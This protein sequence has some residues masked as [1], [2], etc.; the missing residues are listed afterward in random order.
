MTTD[1][2]PADFGWTPNWDDASG[3]FDWWFH[4]MDSVMNAGVA[5]AT[6]QLD[7][8]DEVGF[9]AVRKL[10]ELARSADVR[11]W[12]L[13]VSFTHPHDPHVMRRRYWDRYDLNAIDLPRVGPLS[14]DQLDAHSRRLRHVSAMDEVEITEEHVRRARRAYYAAISY[15]DDWVATL[16]DKLEAC[17]M[18]DD[19]VVIFTADHGD[20]L[21][22]RGLWY[23][24]CF[25][26]GACRI[27]LVVAG[28]DIAARLVPE[29]VSL[30]DVLPTLLDLAGV[31]R[32]ATVDGRSLVP[33]LSGDRDPD[34]TVIGEYLA[35]GAIAPILMIR[36]RELKFVWCDADPPQLYDLGN[37]PD[38]LVNLAA[39]DDHRAVVAELEKE[40]LARWAPVTLRDEVIANQRARRT[41][42]A[43][44]RSGRYSLWEYQPSVDSSQQYM[45]N[46]LDLNEVER[47]RRLRRS[48]Q[49]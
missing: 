31:E 3:R 45:R 12:L 9:Q 39:D 42:Y 28:P 20:L 25:F 34:R 48:D 23:K 7:F 30:L 8:D 32:P 35:E 13:A 19:T 6:N 41:V 33:L 4:N 5:E 24:M 15:V 47:S 21:G 44:L 49:A 38:E 37:D 1:I 17:G 29:H 18:A 46:H 16:L 40:V 11:P 10:R 14:D 27:P 2:Y 36:R 26:E 43:A 22:E